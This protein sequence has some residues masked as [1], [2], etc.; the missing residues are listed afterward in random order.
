MSR[1]F[2]EYPLRRR[3]QQLTESPA[4]ERPISDHAGLFVSVAQNPRFADGAIREWYRENGA[5]PPTSPKS[6]LVDGFES[7]RIK[8][9][10]LH[11]MKAVAEGGKCHY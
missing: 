7:Q 5:Q 8:R 9:Y 4:L 1:E 10:L 11:E 3:L 6:I 2:A